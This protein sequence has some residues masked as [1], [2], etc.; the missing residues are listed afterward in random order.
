MEIYI[1]MSEGQDGHNAN[2]K[3][4]MPLAVVNI[5]GKMEHIE[6]FLLK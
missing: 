1:T 5:Y 6:P 3:V 4:E 2:T